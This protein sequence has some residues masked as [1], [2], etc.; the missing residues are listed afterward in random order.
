MSGALP[1]TG[2]ASTSC[3]YFVGKPTSSGDSYTHEDYTAALLPRSRWYVVPMG[4]CFRL[5]YKSRQVVV[6]V[7]DRGKGKTTRKGAADP[8]RVLD[9][10]R[11]AMAYLSGRSIS[12]ITDSNA[13]V[14][15][16]STIQVVPP[17]TTLGPVSPGDK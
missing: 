16:L 9:L 11:A 5:T 1:T 2:E 15:Q 4:T 13:G 14:I 6:K 7:N 17:G 3:D 12:H 8:S 10:S